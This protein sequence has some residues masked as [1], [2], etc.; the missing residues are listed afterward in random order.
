MKVI[1]ICKI[2][3]KF[4]GYSYIWLLWLTYLLTYLLTHLLR[5]S[6]SRPHWDTGRRVSSTGC[7]HWQLSLLLSRWLTLLV[8]HPWRWSIR[9]INLWSSLFSFARWLHLPT[10]P[11]VD[12][13]SVQCPTRFNLLNLTTSD[14]CCNIALLKTLSL[15]TWSNH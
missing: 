13:V 1:S 9:H 14:R 5:L 6:S 15:A 7:G 2:W 3:M 11:L 12:V 10:F 8:D 4:A